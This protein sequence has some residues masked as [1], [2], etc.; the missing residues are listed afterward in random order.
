M[1]KKMTKKEM[2]AKLRGMVSDNAEMVKFIDHEIELLEKKNSSK[3]GKPT[4]NQLAN[5][6]IKE[7]I[8]EFL[9]DNGAST[10]TQIMKGV[11]L[12]S[13]QKTSA[14]V[15]QLKEGGLVI[16][17]VEKGVAYFTKA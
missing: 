4:A 16:R 1:E 2:F 8:L 3:S 17:S 11:G 9:N 7:K 5:E 13:N 12:E 6:G 14:L 10:V 15:R